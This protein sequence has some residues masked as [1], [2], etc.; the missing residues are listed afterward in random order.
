MLIHLGWEAERTVIRL[1]V[2]IRD[3]ERSKTTGLTIR[4]R[5]RPGRADFIGTEP[6]GGAVDGVEVTVADFRFE[7]EEYFPDRIVE[8]VLVDSEL[9]VNREF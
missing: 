9:R 7:E 4:T 6:R 3:H 2:G 1:P 8:V 5:E